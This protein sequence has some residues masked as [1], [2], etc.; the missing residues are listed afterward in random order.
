MD[1]AMDDA[2]DDG[3]QRLDPR[4][5]WVLLAPSYLFTVLPPRLTLV[6]LLT[7]VVL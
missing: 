5:R 7:I 1:D 6:V 2:M 4:M 3:V